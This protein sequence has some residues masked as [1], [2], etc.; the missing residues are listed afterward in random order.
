MSKREALAQAL[1]N[2]ADWNSFWS[3]DEVLV[4]VDAL[5]A[6]LREPDEGMLENRAWTRYN[7]GRGNKRDLWQDIVDGIE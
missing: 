6:E 7:E 5:L 3:K 1:L 4:L 2:C